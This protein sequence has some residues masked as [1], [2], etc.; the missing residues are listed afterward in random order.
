MV[1]RLSSLKAKFVLSL[2]DVPDVRRIFKQFK[3]REIEL[4]YTAQK[5]AG[6]RYKEVLITNF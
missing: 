2:N 5:R 1:R 6:R 4:Y 3:F